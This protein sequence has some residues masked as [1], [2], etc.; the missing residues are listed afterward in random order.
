MIIGIYPGSFDPLTNGHL[1]ILERSRKMCDKL[2][3]AVARNIS[4]K[5]LFTIEERLDIIDKSY[6]CDDGVE[7]VTFDGLLVEYCKNNNVTFIVRGVRAIIDFEY[8]HA[9]ALMN[10]QLAPNI[11]TIFLM[12]KSEYSFL[13]SSMI[14]EVALYG[15]NVTSLVP[16][17][18]NQKLIEKFSS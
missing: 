11:E 9:V 17:F 2:I 7:I 4:K 14:K 5:P 1:D 16:Q 18:V 8:E 12:A 10:R 15:G 3:I 13:S 6:N